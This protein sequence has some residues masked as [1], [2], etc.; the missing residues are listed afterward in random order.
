MIDPSNPEI[1]RLVLAAHPVSVPQQR[2]SQQRHLQGIERRPQ[3]DQL[4]KTLPP[5]DMGKI[6]LAIART[7]PKVLMAHIEHGFQP[8]QTLPTPGSPQR[9]AAVVAAAGVAAVAARP[10][11]RST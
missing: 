1:L 7:N 9:R 8:P 3:L 10:T 11:R 2:R 5:G 6:G 4:T